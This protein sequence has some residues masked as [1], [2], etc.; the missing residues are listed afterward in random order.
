V[1]DPS[2]P[3]DFPASPALNQV[4]I[5]G[6]VAWVWDGT[7]WVMSATYSGPFLPLS[8]GNMAGP[9]VLAADPVVALGAATKHYVDVGNAAQV[10]AMNDNRIINGDMRI[11]QRNNGATVPV[12]SGVAAF[13]VD[14]FFSSGSQVGKLS[15]N[16]ASGASTGAVGFPYYLNVA[17]LTA[18]TPLVAD[19]FGINQSLEGDMISDLLW[20][21]SN[22]QPVTLSFW[23]NTTVPGTYSGS[24]ANGDGTRSYPFTFNL[25]GV[26]Q[27]FIINIPGDT[28]GT[29]V[30]NGNARSMLVRWSMGCGA[31]FLGAANAWVGGN[32]V[33][34]TGSVNLCANNGASFVLTGVKLEIGNVA[35][36]F[37]R[38]SLSKSMADCQ[39]YFQI[40]QNY[41]VST[42]QAAGGAFNCGTPFA[43]AMRATPTMTMMTNSSGNFT[44][45]TINSNQYMIAS[46]TGVSIAAGQTALNIIWSANAEM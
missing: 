23:A 20:G 26:L 46:V 24:I 15:M 14:R 43:V 22:A 11:D 8:G 35:T 4:Y 29:W 13:S 30:L 2:S 18:Y 37:N 45:G 19:A 6:N 27:K 39:R 12:T 9:I 25:T 10:V 7:K 1:A 17:S 16:R 44:F 41:I 31:N 34:V 36:P 28:A 40:G 42:G 21:T 38:Q 32:I 3:L 33:G 5:V